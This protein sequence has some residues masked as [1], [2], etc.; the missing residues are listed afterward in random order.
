MQAT[1]K[2]GG[3]SNPAAVLYK[4]PPAPVSWTGLYAGGSLDAGFGRTTW[5]DPFGPTPLGDYVAMGGALAGGQLGANYQT[6]AVVYGLEAAGS[7]AQIVGTFTCFAGNPNQTVAGQ[8]CGAKVGALATLTGRIGYAMDRTLYYAKAG[9][10]W[11][12]STLQLNFASAAAGQITTTAVDRTGW[13][14]GA[15]VEQGLTDRWSIVG[16]Y[17]YVD[18]GSAQVMFAGAPPVIA[19]VGTTAVNQHYQV[20]T[21]GVN[22]KLN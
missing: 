2:F 9:P 6:G 17:R 11:A 13:T 16:E 3:N 12:R 8:D 15:G 20:L 1:Y 18:L 4:A 19:P 22:Y 21:L 5:S 7:W 10:A 14:I